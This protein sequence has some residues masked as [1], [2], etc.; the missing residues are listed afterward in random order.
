MNIET[1]EQMSPGGTCSPLVKLIAANPY[2]IN[3]GVPPES[4]GRMIGTFTVVPSNIVQINAVR[5]TIDF[6]E[7]HV[8][9]AGVLMYNQVVRM[10]V[11]RPTFDR[12][13]AMYQITNGH[14]MVF[15]TS[16]IGEQKMIGRRAGG[17]AFRFSTSQKTERIERNEAIIEFIST[18]PRPAPVVQNPI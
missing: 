1:H 18:Q 12:L 7:S 15:V 9:V 8:D 6:E 16:N 11:S 17:A 13:N 5:D 4:N 2:A 10:V 3:N 14:W